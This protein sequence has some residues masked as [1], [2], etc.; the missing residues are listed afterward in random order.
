[1][2][3]RN[4]LAA[5]ALQTCALVFFASAAP[6]M[7]QPQ[8][9]PSDVCDANSPG[10]DPNTKNCTQQPEG[11]PGTTAPG[12]NP[13]TAPSD[14]QPTPANT[15]RG[16]ARAQENTIVITGSRIPRPQFEGT[17]PGV[18]VTGQ[19]VAVRAF[20]SAS[21]ALRDQ[22]LVS[23]FG[24]SVNGTNGGQPGSLGSSFV[25]LLGLG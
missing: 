11:R 18:Q 23:R 3:N 12:T 13:G 19:Q 24:P 10:Y 8:S 4:L 16:P 15:A 21:E 22:P 5:T 6:A 20:N 9:P 7:A 1:M 25:D 2:T 14:E 17:I